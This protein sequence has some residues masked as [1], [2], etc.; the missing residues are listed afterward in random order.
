MAERGSHLR[1][2]VP[3]PATV[4]AAQ[5]GRPYTRARRGPTHA[6]GGCAPQVL[7]NISSQPPLNPLP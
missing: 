6:P 7:L 5:P 4:E 3:H 2:E 1:S